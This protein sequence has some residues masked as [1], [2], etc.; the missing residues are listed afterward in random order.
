L[1]PKM[2]RSK[3]CFS[4]GC[5]GRSAS[6]FVV[7]SYMESIARCVTRSE[8]HL[9]PI[10]TGFVSA[11]VDGITLG[12]GD[13]RRGEGGVHCSRRDWLP[14]S[15]GPVRSGPP[16]PAATLPGR[17][18]IGPGDGCSGS[19]AGRR[20]VVE[21]PGSAAVGG[22]GRGP[23]SWTKAH[24]SPRPRYG[25]APLR[26]LVISCRPP[27]PSPPAELARDRSGAE[28]VASKPVGN[29]SE[30]RLRVDQPTR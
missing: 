12:A 2:M 14:A 18:R 10:E 26:S 6:R 11:Q 4:A 24:A 28:P 9:W 22:R 23:A 25:W 8:R 19:Y 7:E 15:P 1:R 30:S 27:R 16:K 17:H 20:E 29:R 3:E 21:G 13:P 5:L